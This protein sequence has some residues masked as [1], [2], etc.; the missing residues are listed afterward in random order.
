MTP[1]R[2][3]E[4]EEV[5]GWDTRVTK[6]KNGFEAFVLLGIFFAYFI[7]EKTIPTMI[8]IILLVGSLV[9]LGS[10]LGLD[11]YTKVTVQ[12]YTGQKIEAGDDVDPSIDSSEDT[13]EVR[14][15]AVSQ[16]QKQKMANEIIVD[17]YRY[18]I[19]YNPGYAAFVMLDMS[20]VFLVDRRT[21]SGYPVRFEMHEL[22]DK[23]KK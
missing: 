15:I 20:G 8:F 13:Q 22:L 3:I 9:I 18:G 21:H 10:V 1:R 7:T 16:Q 2:K 6:P 17:G 14:F 23:A 4:P 11:E 19:Q 5:G 12:T